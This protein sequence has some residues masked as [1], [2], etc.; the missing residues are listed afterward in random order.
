[1]P[2]RRRG[3]WMFP[4]RR[5]A[6]ARRRDGRGTQSPRDGRAPEGTASIVPGQFSTDPFTLAWPGC[7]AD[8]LIDFRGPARRSWSASPSPA[9]HIVHRSPSDRARRAPT[10]SRVGRA[11][12]ARLAGLAGRFR[13]SW[14]RSHWRGRS[15]VTR[16]RAPGS[17]RLGRPYASTSR[18]TCP[19]FPRSAPAPAA[20]RW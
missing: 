7:S 6:G 8:V 14:H 17:V 20:R 5:G 19:R 3:L 2:P 18:A 12:R 9:P 13:A 15:R 16:F 1:M 10:G 4:A 11:L